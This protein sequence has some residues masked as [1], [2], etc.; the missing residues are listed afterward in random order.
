MFN[1]NQYLFD[2]KS[3]SKIYT[4]I[5]PLLRSSN[6]HLIGFKPGVKIY[7]TLMASSQLTKIKQIDSENIYN[8]FTM[9]NHLSAQN[10]CG[11]NSM[12]ISHKE[13]TNCAIPATHLKFITGKI[14]P[15][16]HKKN[17]SITHN[18]TLLTMGD[19]KSDSNYLKYMWRITR[20][21]STQVHFILRLP[22]TITCSWVNETDVDSVTAMTNLVRHIWFKSYSL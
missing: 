14:S 16:N 18:G 2:I 21:I 4:S 6:L 15:Q 12:R 10:L 11:T 3:D 1:T 17:V 8:L 20:T 5:L 9:Q 19:S 22:V 13:W 7:R